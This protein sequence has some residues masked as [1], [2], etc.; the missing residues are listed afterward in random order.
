M[1]PAPRQLVFDLSHR[2]ALGAEDFFVSTSNSA[3]VA[4]I[5]QWPDWPH[6]AAVVLGAGGSGKSHLANVW[7]HRSEAM[8]IS[9]AELTDAAVEAL[10]EK[11]ALCIEDI[12]RGINDAT[13]LF[14]LL[15]LARE[16][17]QSI[18]LTTR[19][20]PGDLQIELPDL[21][22]RLRA[23]PLVKIDEPD[24][25]LLTAVLV[26][27]FSDRQLQVEPK[28]IS[29]L[30]LRMERSMAFASRL[31]AE[32]DRLALARQRRVTTPLA[33]EAL[34]RTS[35]GKSSDKPA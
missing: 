27:L 4:L 17:K 9:G 6:W 32:I 19:L 25:S 11:G 10:N 3:A 5:D 21:R 2:S 12:D 18:L 28:V 14:H 35:E 33:Q 15:N 8:V 1:T 23:L 29:Y 22:S 34:M 13:L 30:S 26:K 7:R 20:A 24:E 16:H 31:V